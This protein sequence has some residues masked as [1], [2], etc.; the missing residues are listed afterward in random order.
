M[1][2]SQGTLQRHVALME[3]LPLS[4]PTIKQEGPQQLMAASWGAVH[5]ESPEPP[6]D[7]GAQ[8]VALPVGHWAQWGWA[9]LLVWQEA[10][11]KPGSPIPAG[12]CLAAGQRCPAAGG[13]QSGTRHCQQ[14]ACCLLDSEIWP[15]LARI[16]FNYDKQ[17]LHPLSCD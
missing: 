9:A 1:R 10:A 5:G 6:R 13:P 16:Q 11:R 12:R 17:R 14:A 15:Q 7:A 2:G 4:L 8:T 3:T